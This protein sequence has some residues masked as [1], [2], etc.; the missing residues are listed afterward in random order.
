MSG[1]QPVLSSPAPLVVKAAFVK[2][3]FA[4]VCFAELLSLIPLLSE[5][6]T[7]LAM[8]VLV[9]IVLVMSASATILA[10]PS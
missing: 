4:F 8:V 1:S 6:P 3:R 2:R 5:V 7:A 10:S 9:I